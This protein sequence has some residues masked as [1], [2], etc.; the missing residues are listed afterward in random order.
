M[1]MNNLRIILT[2]IAKAGPARM[3][4]TAALL[5]LLTAEGQTYAAEEEGVK[6]SLC[7]G[8]I[9]VTSPVPLTLTEAERTLVCGD[10]DTAAWS[11]IPPRQAVYFLKQFFDNR[12]YHRV[13]A[14]I[15]GRQITV[16]T[17]AVVLV[18]DVVLTYDE[19]KDETAR[20]A[21]AN[22]DTSRYWPIYGR[23]LTSKALDDLQKWLSMQ[24]AR[25][26]MPCVLM[27]MQ[28]DTETGIV[29][30]AVSAARIFKIGRIRADSIPGVNGGI[31][32]RQ[33]AFDE[34]DVY[35]ALELDLSAQRL[36]SSDVVV[37]S[38][39]ITHCVADGAQID[40]E[41]QMIAGEPRLVSFGFGFD[42]EEYAIT[43][44]SWRHARLG[45]SASNLTLLARASY[46][47]QTA[48]ASFDWYYAPIAT[49]HFLRATAFHERINERR[50]D[51]GTSEGRIGPVWA[52]DLS[53]YAVQLFAGSAF[54]HIE[55]TRGVGPATSD[56]VVG[57]VSAEAT[58]HEFEYFA[59]SPQSGHQL[60]W[61]INRAKKSLGSDMSFSRH[62]IKA[63]ALWTLFAL[64]PPIWILGL[65]GTAASTTIDEDTTLDEMPLTMRNF[66]G[67]SE[68]MRGF[69]RNAI[70]A[71][72]EGA[73]TTVYAGAEMRVRE[74]I[75]YNIHPMV[76]VDYGRTG[77]D[78]TTLTKD[79]FWSPGLGV[80]WQSPIGTFR[81]TFAHGFINGPSH[82]KLDYMSRW[83]FYLSFGEQF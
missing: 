67:G 63:T 58:T 80:Q 55:T 2:A 30:V 45:P 23:P 8:R 82:E 51:T 9:E 28:A 70:P 79:E 18:R 31:Q 62:Q 36:V 73:L 60:N 33:Y 40:I 53:N 42:T 5:S 11:D 57:I 39:F 46:R 27:A 59:Q 24:L 78:D 49:N 64:D 1:K 38:S 35:D 10:A 37:A 54:R 29:T 75:P 77:G 74:V 47:R 4:L 72:D 32:K 50:E 65:R 13:E 19:V 17:G 44:A 12:G 25:R 41:Q 6:D 81:T 16:R 52:I 56:A 48:R 66:L 3:L 7:N 71:S 83:Q 26:G 69:G 34:G 21:L 15:D 22:I 20:D 14:T 43:E 61:E 76:F 68:D